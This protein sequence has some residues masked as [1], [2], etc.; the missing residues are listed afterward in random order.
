MVEKDSPAI[1]IIA[2]I[3]FAT[4]Q[5]VVGKLVSVQ[6]LSPLGVKRNPADIVVALFP[7]T[8]L[9]LSNFTNIPST[10]KMN[11]F[12]LIL[13]HALIIRSFAFP[14]YPVPTLRHIRVSDSAIM[15]PIP[16]MP[17]GKIRYMFSVI[18][19]MANYTEALNA[20]TTSCISGVSGVGMSDIGPFKMHRFT[21]HFVQVQYFIHVSPNETQEALAAIESF[22]DH[23]ES[24]QPSN[25]LTECIRE[26]DSTFPPESHLFRGSTLI[27]PYQDA[28]SEEAYNPGWVIVEVIGVTMVCGVVV[29][30]VLATRRE[31]LYNVYEY[32]KI[33]D[34]ESGARFCRCG[35]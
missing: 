13:L 28:L 25:R 29:L 32:D 30:A 1:L 4:T 27:A 15:V 22:F 17:K 19:S 24:V 14:M 20:A 10:N 5:S 35:E 16:A 8:P 18:S 26:R 33:E 11:M 21:K 2:Y 3:S 34:I 7:C 31:V 9:L 12:V 23:T 6:F